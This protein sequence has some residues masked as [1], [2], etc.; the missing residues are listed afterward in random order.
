MRD[1]SRKEGFQILFWR[2][3]VSFLNLFVDGT[4]NPGEQQKIEHLIRNR[5][6]PEQNPITFLSCTNEDSQGMGE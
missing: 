6:F 3:V 1:R 5:P 4:P 2:F